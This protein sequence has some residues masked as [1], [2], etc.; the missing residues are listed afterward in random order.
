MP[1]PWKCSRSGWMGLWWSGLDRGVLTDLKA[2][3][4]GDLSDPF[5]LKPFYNHVLFLLDCLKKL[6][7]K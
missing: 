4:L 7:N 1:H 2:M 5:Q 6:K 3:E